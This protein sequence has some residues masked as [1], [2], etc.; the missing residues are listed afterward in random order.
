MSS[1]WQN[2]VSIPKRA[3]LH[4]NISADVLVIGGGMAG[5]LC[6]HMLQKGGAK[7]VLL[8][9]G[10]IGGGQTAGTTAKITQQHGLVYDKLV[11]T[12]G[13][14]TAEIFAR[15]NA[16]ALCEFALLEEELSRPSSMQETPSYIYLD[17]DD[18]PQPLLREHAA[19]KR[20]GLP[21]ELLPHAPLPMLTGAAVRMEGGFTFHPLRFLKAVGET[22]TIFEDSRV[23]SFEN[24]VART[25]HGSVRAGHTIVAT[26]FP[27]INFPG[28]YFMRMHQQQAYGISLRGASLEEGM[29]LNV[30]REGLSLRSFGEYVI[31]VGSGGRCGEV[32]G[33]QYERLRAKAKELFPCAEVCAQWSAQDCMPQT[34]L[35]FIG[36]YAA[37][38]NLYVATGFAKWGMSGSMLAALCLSKEIVHGERAYGG[39]FAPSHLYPAAAAAPFAKDT[40]NVAANYAHTILETPR[41]KMHG[42]R[43]GEAAVVLLEGERVCAYH[44]QD[45]KIYAV[46]FKCPHLGC[47]LSWNPSDKTWDCPCHGSRFSYTGVCIAGPA[48]K[49]LELRVFNGQDKECN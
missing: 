11:K 33:A 36:K 22:I 35:P 31:M 26:H 48:Q 2:T 12:H 3:Q 20:L 9:A 21:A 8:E 38:D 39:I 37:A 29:F 43:R 46:P 44:A 17:T 27:F 18:D 5:V 42:L 19:A 47:A 16:D 32:P 10:R 4:G 7:T 45:G 40:A 6:A 14:E 41:K 28:L 23:L 30:G 25:K 24:G 15:A 34:G 1:I 49:P 13:E